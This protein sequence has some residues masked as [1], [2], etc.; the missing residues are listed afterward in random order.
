MRGKILFLFAFLII[1][2]LSVFAIEPLENVDGYE[3]RYSS[4]LERSGV[5][6]Q[7]PRYIDSSNITFVIMIRTSQDSKYMATLYMQL[8]VLSNNTM[9]FGG[10]EIPVKGDG[11]SVFWASDDS[12]IE[13]FPNPANNFPIKLLEGYLDE[14][15]PSDMYRN[16]IEGFCN[17][18]RWSHAESSYFEYTGKTVRCDTDRMVG[19]EPNTTL[20][21]FRYDVENL[22]PK[23]LLEEKELE[24]LF[25]KCKADGY[26]VFE[27]RQL[28]GFIK[29]CFDRV[30]PIISP[31]PLENENFDVYSNSLDICETVQASFEK[32]KNTIDKFDETFDGDLNN[33]LIDC[34]VKNILDQRQRNME[35]CKNR[36][37][38]T[39]DYDEMQCPEDDNVREDAKLDLLI[40]AKEAERVRTTAKKIESLKVTPKE[41]QSAQAEKSSQKSSANEL[42]EKKTDDP[43]ITP[44][45][46]PSEENS[47]PGKM[48]FF[49]RIISFFKSWFS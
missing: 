17:N 37:L 7:M 33:T 49:G 1:S 9:N 30:Y 5:V 26:V 38:G 6:M 4:P 24:P 42:I 20:E 34:R 35:A 29:Q 8:S 31:V 48:T 3:Y 46:Q 27:G 39:E 18:I 13:A 15:N 14:F 16:S 12:I 28:E 32:N 43:I 23:K 44:Q 11:K 36:V 10:Y 21:E 25:E 47:V 2:S 40:D 45:V 19:P 41:V 22:P